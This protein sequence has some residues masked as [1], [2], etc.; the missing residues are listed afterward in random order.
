MSLRKL[1]PNSGDV[2]PIKSLDRHLG[3][4]LH[5]RAVL[6]LTTWVAS[7]RDRLWAGEL[8]RAWGRKVQVE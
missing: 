2:L 6:A 8:D 1:Y 5:P 3:N 7:Q 4:P